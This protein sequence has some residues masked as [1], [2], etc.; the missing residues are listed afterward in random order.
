MSQVRCRP[1]AGPEARLRRPERALRVEVPC[2]R[3]VE[4]RLARSEQQEPGRPSAR[5]LEEVVEGVR[6]SVQPAAAAEQPSVALAEEVVVQ[7]SARPEVAAQPWEPRAVAEEQPSAG[8]VAAVEV[9]RA[10]EPAAVAGQPSEVRV[11]E[12]ER[13]WAALAAEREPPSAAQVVLLSAAP[14][15]RSDPPVR[16]LARQRTTTFRREP[17]AAKPEGRRSQL[18]SAE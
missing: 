11:V 18:S 8:Q 17:E 7:P 1:E 3:A 13:P 6:P 12:A 2:A 9:L 15:V 14:S 4:V 5:R 16:R 10:A